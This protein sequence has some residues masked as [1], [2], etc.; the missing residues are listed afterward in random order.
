MIKKV[1]IPEPQKDE[2]IINLKELTN[3]H[4]WTRILIS[5]WKV[6]LFIRFDED[7]NLKFSINI[8][9]LPGEDFDHDKPSP[10]E[11]LLL[12]TINEVIKIRS[13][14]WKIAVE[15]AIDAIHKCPYSKEYPPE[16]LYLEISRVS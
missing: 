14:T 5:F 3:S 2:S 10:K 9:N 12:K 11:A 6:I 16:V 8:T 15:Q 13:L 4:D 1:I 7:D